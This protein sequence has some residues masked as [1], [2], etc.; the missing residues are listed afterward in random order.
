MRSVV[1]LMVLA[2]ATP[3]WAQTNADMSGLWATSEP[4]ATVRI[5]RCGRGFCGSLA[6]VGE[7]TV[8][9]NNPNP[10]LRNRRLV[11]L[12]VFAAGAPIPNGQDGTL[13]NPK[14][15][16]TYSGRLVMKGP[17]AIEVSGCVLGI[18]CRS[19]NWSRLR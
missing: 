15:G 14:D 8:D 18:L 1:P 7:G 11:G 16:K 13:Y 10:A 2:L 17:N 5:A 12:Q 19:Q 6:S 4:G 3:A 9:V